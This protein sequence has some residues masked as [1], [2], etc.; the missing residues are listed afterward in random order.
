MLAK[1]FAFLKNTFNSYCQSLYI[2][3]NK[4]IISNPTLKKNTT[5]FKKLN[6]KRL[7]QTQKYFCQN[8]NFEVL[9]SYGPWAMGN[10]CFNFNFNRDKSIHSGGDGGAMLLFLTTYSNKK[11]LA[12]L[13][14]LFLIFF[15]FCKCVIVNCHL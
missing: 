8:K 13:M 3:R 1:H 12:A 7:N 15:F 2:K 4:N 14:L 6:Y 10:R 5:F 9:F 11:K